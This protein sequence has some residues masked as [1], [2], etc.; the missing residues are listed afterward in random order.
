MKLR[1]KEVSSEKT[2]NSGFID[3]AADSTL[4]GILISTAPLL[5]LGFWSFRKISQKISNLWQKIFK[6]VS[7]ELKK[8]R[9]TIDGFKYFILKSNEV[10]SQKLHEY[11]C[12]DSQWYRKE[13]ITP[14]SVDEVP[15]DIREKHKRK[16]QNQNAEIDVSKEMKEQLELLA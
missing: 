13:V 5:N 2:D 10:L 9:E 11:W 15:A 16:L 6:W 7:K 8:L 3:S 4:S 14:I 1:K 12:K